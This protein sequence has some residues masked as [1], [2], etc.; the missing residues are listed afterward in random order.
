MFKVIINIVLVFLYFKGNNNSVRTYRPVT[1]FQRVFFGNKDNYSN[2]MSPT[3]KIKSLNP[4][5]VFIELNA[6]EF[7]DELVVEADQNLQKFFF[8]ESDG[9]TLKF[10]L[11]SFDNNT[12]A[13]IYY[14]ARQNK[15]VV[16]DERAQNYLKSRTR[17][18]VFIK[19]SHPTL[20][21]N[22]LD[23]DVLNVYFKLNRNLSYQIQ[24]NSFNKFNCNGQILF[25]NEFIENYRNETLTLSS[26]SPNLNV[27]VY[28]C[29]DF[30]DLSV[31]E[32]N[33]SVVFSA[34]RIET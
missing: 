12:D 7:D 17:T 18:K 16:L 21:I 34:A 22:K 6:N 33:G 28:F 26:R 14:T 10:Y 8:T 25:N 20:K 24:H 3:Y 27:F 11:D 5:Y 31:N 19:S 30:F 2:E 32:S 15:S 9:Q 4:I 29:S 1:K 23:F 13:S